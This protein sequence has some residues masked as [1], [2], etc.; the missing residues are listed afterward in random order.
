MRFPV[1]DERV[2]WDKIHPEYAP[3]EHTD[4]K[5]FKQFVTKGNNGWA[6]PEDLP[7]RA[8]TVFRSYTGYIIRGDETGRPLNPYGRTGITGR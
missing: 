5:V 7:A 6:D 2:L 1:T 8:D 3:R 4:V